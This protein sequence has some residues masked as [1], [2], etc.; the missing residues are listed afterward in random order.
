MFTGTEGEPLQLVVMADVPAMIYRTPVGVE[1]IWFPDA[2]SGF[3][4]LDS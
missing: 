2:G 1:Q 4:F 3:E